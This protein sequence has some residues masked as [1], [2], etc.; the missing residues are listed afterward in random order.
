VN[1]PRIERLEAERG[2]VAPFWR[3]GQEVRAP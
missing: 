3:S 1:K 2:K